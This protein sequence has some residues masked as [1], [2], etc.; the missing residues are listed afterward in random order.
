MYCIIPY[1]T[2]FLTK[3]YKKSINNAILYYKSYGFGII[4]YSKQDYK[5]IALTPYL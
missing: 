4:I 5:L 2:I 3:Y 1:S